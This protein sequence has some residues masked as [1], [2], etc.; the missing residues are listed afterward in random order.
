[1]TRRKMRLR[2]VVGR[3]AAA[4]IVISAFMSALGSSLAYGASGAPLTIA[5]QQMD[6]SLTFSAGS[7]V[8]AG[9]RFN[10][11]GKAPVSFNGA[12]VTLPVSCTNGGSVAAGTIV[13]Q[14]AT[15]P[16]TPSGYTY[17]PWSS[18]S[19]TNPLSYQGAV[20]APNLCN[21]APMYSESQV[22]GATFSANVT[23][24]DSSTVNVEFHYAVPAG[25]N[26]TNTDCYDSNSPGALTSSICG[27]TLSATGTANPTPGPGANVLPAVTCVS[28]GSGSSYTAYFGYSNSGSA[29][30]YPLGT[31]NQ[32]TP[33][34]LDGSEPTNFISG[35]V[36]NAFSVLVPSGSVTW[37]VAGQAASASASSTVCAGS[38]LFND[39]LGLSL[40]LALS[41]GIG[42]GVVVIRRTARGRR[43]S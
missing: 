28:L 37:T 11:H 18:V 1:M 20:Q 39:P 21:G 7:W 24:T 19:S 5:N 32:V 15:G 22:G 23:S 17:A 25:A 29:V 3:A 43:V 16:Y 10:T 33:T 41:L 12:Q 31:S 36:T 38:S 9:Y 6:G 40:V 4:L 30:T 35:N 26:Q 42:S 27:T 34:S 8:S 14:L 13:V 2:W